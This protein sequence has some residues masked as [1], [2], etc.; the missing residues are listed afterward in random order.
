MPPVRLAIALAAGLLAAVRLGAQEPDRTPLTIVKATGDIEVDGD[1]S[2]AT[3]ATASPI[4]TWY[5]TNPGDNVTPS[6]TNVGY[7]AYDDRYLYAAF[8][9]GDQDP[10]A[11]RAPLG[12]RDNVPGETD[13][14]GII[15]DTRNTGKTA[16]LFLANARGIQYDA[17][18]DDASGED[19]SPDFFWD[20]AARITGEGWT[21]EMRIPFSTLRYPKTDVQSWRVMLYRNHPRAY[22]Y[23]YFSTRL[24]RGSSCF[25]C[26]TQPLTGLR[27]L[28]SGGN[29]VLAPYATGTVRGTPRAGLGSRLDHDGDGD[30]GLDLKWTPTANTAVD[31][32]V[33]PDFS[34][35][36]S[37][38]AQIAANERFALFFSEKRPF[39]LEGIELFSTPIQ[40]VYTRTITSPRW[41][42]RSTGKFGSTAYTALLAEDRGGGSVIIPGA[43]ASGFADQ[44]FR[45]YV[46]LGRLRRD[47]GRSFVSV[48]ATDRESDGGAHNRVLGPDFQWRPSDRH[49]L[50]GQLLF[51]RSRTPDRPDLADEWTGQD[52]SG[53]A[54]HL[55]YQRTTAKSDLFL[56]GRDV[57]T[58]FRADS[59]FVPQAGFRQTFAETGRT[60]RPKGFLRRIRT[61]AWFERST[62]RDGELLSRQ[63]SF[64]SGMDGRW[65]SFLRGVYTIDRVRSG[66]RTF[67]RQRF[68]YVVE[69]SPSRVFSRVSLSGWVG[70]EVDFAN[71]RVGDGA[72]VNLYAS[73]RPTNHLELRVN[74][75]RRWLDV[76]AARASGRLFTASVARLRATYTFTARSFVRLVGQYVET[77]R[78]PGLYTFDV[79]RRSASFESSALFAYK[80]NWQTVLFV[81]CGDE[82]SLDA[83]TDR[84]RRAGRQF[85]VKLSYALQR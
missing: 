36:E 64:G 44:A 52:L 54:A 14:A 4:D 5:E 17:I 21:L 20:A 39:F 79:A 12:D 7:L 19:S 67:P 24:P 75:S 78:D 47:L 68:N 76:E 9:F 1:L 6:V 31:A 70:Q 15:L 8:R 40:A 63:V 62:G 29:L 73:I 26:R 57:G 74:G 85:F 43:N 38:V 33:N 42:V 82:E 50:T 27:G 30:V 53:H 13:Y 3:W 61:F 66:A 2:D 11:I 46:L 69:A 32:T 81:G 60:F 16:T 51:S 34:Q 22:R 59:G 48:L 83:E 18:S 45:S 10:K 71:E 58:G 84:L 55:W 80:L 23:Q 72:S 77:E 25:I 65:N 35:V 56:E 49:T 28:P 37:D 41:G